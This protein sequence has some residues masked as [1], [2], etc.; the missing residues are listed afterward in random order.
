MELQNLLKIQVQANLG[1]FT[2]QYCDTEIL[3]A[4]AFHHM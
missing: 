4:S 1:H 3:F 2:V